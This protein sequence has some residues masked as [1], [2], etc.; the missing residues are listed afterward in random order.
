MKVLYAIQ[1]TGNGH[2]SRATAIIPVLEKYCE[3]DVL[4]SGT[5]ADI[6]IN[7][8][9]KFKLRGLSFYFGKKGG[10]DIWETFNKAS[11]IRLKH[12]FDTLPVDDYDLVINDFEPVSAWACQIK[13]VPCIALSHQSALLEP[14]V[15]LPEEKDLVGSFVLKNY[16]PT[17]DFIGFHFDR[18]TS[19]IYTPVIRNDIRIARPLDKGH[20]TV[21]LPAYDDYLLASIL[22]EVKQTSWE[23][24]SK[25]GNQVR[26]NEHIHIRPVNGA[27]FA[28]SLLHSSGVLCGAGFETPAEALFLGKKLMVVPMK[29]QYEQHCN[30]AALARMGVPVLSGV[31]AKFTDR[32]SEFTEA[33]ETVRIDYPDQLEDIVAHMFQLAAKLEIS[34]SNSFLKKVLRQRGFAQT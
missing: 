22:S 6:S 5:Q 8:P 13:E 12:E 24:F 29:G 20:Y 7:Y 9:V 14:N 34:D 26:Y 33:S 18:Y 32:I 15:P 25:S 10:V 1:G 28:Q 30:A 16:A 23:I 4:V 11:L 17:H 3:L 27:D 21:Y 31:N 19:R 2:L